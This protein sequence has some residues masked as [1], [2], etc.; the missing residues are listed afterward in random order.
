MRFLGQIGSEMDP[1][2]LCLKVLVPKVA[3]S[4]SKIRL[5]KFLEK[6]IM[7]RFDLPTQ[8]IFCKKSCTGAFAQKVAQ[9]QFSNYIEFF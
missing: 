6:S 7:E 1:N 5:F 8:I 3:Q 4:D 9:N 2:K